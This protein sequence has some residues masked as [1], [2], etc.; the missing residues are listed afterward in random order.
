MLGQRKDRADIEARQ[1]VGGLQIEAHGVVVD[2]HHVDDRAG[3]LFGI[4]DVV[5]DREIEM[6]LGI[7]EGED[8]VGG[9]ER[10]AVGPLDAF[11]QVVG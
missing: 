2:R 1:R 4:V 5:A 10:L 3:V 6:R 11:T 9:G 8:H 7:V